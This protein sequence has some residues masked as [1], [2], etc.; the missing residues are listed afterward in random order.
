MNAPIPPN[1]P[2]A[3]NVVIGSNHNNRDEANLGDGGVGAEGVWDNLEVTGGL[4]WGGSGA[5][6]GPERV[7][8]SRNGT[9]S[10]G[11]ERGCGAFGRGEQ[12]VGTIDVGN[13]WRPVGLRLGGSVGSERGRAG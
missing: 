13:R 10:G 8:R 7:K 4:W 6:S 3:V 1:A 12:R 5:L 11:F 2:I 9:N